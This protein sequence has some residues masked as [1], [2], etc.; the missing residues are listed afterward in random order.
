MQVLQP[1][2]WQEPRGF[3]NGVVARGRLVFTAGQIGWDARNHLCSPHMPEQVRQ[4]LH[5]VLAVVEEAGGTREDIV[6]LTWFITD[7]R[8]YGDNQKE[9]GD[10]YRQIMGRHYP[11]MS[12][13][14]VASLLEDGAKVEIE[15]TAVVP[16]PAQ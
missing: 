4:A 6:R 13:V 14:E 1:W 3:V 11:A 8:E 12:V 2:G 9:I 10:V 15:A 7:K 16:D 5:N